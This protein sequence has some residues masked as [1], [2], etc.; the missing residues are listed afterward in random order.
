MVRDVLHRG[1]RYYEPRRGE[2]SYPVEFQGAAYRFGHSMV[3]PLQLGANEDLHAG[4]IFD[5]QIGGNGRSR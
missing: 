2:G 5:P 1:R 4:L 3:R